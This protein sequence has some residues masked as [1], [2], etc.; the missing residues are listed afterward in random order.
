MAAPGS[1]RSC[2]SGDDPKDLQGLAHLTEH[3]LFLGSEKYPEHGSFDKV[4]RGPRNYV[5]LS[6]MDYE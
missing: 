1:W 5:L 6:V 4:G 2:G 3:M